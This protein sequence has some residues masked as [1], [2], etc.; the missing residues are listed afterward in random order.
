MALAAII[1]DGTRGVHLLRRVPLAIQAN[2]VIERW[3]SWG[4]DLLVLSER[5]H[6]AK[7]DEEQAQ[8]KL[9]RTELKEARGQIGGLTAAAGCGCAFQSRH[10]RRLMRRR[11]S[12]GGHGG[13]SSVRNNFSAVAKQVY[14]KVDLAGLLGRSSF[15]DLWSFA[16]PRGFSQM[17]VLAP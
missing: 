14:S 8:Q 16:K 7:Q 10:Q 13:V 1:V 17:T 2:G 9:A 15:L 5:D 6:E 4:N 11:R 12:G 3:I